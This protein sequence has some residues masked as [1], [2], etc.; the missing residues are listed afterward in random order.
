[1]NDELVVCCD[2]G[3][4]H[5]LTSTGAFIGHIDGPRDAPIPPKYYAAAFSGSDD[6]FAVDEFGCQLHQFEYR[7]KKT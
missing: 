7:E 2:A 5:V 1:V 4:M 3:S 6:L